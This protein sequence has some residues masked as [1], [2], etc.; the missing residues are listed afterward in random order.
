ML[1]VCFTRVCFVTVITAGR[2]CQM[3]SIMSLIGS[4]LKEIQLNVT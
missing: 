4:I 1:P 3:M 2:H